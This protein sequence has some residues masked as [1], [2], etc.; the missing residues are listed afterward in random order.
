MPLG[1]YCIR[2]DTGSLLSYS[3][4]GDIISLDPIHAVGEAEA[5]AWAA[6]LQGFNGWTT[7][8]GWPR[9]VDPDRRMVNEF[10]T[11][12]LPQARPPRRSARRRAGATRR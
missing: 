8:A 9:T 2:K 5:A 11:E 4:D 12:L 1:S 3:Y 10:F 7:L 6:F